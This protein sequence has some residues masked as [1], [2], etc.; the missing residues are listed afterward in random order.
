MEI[1]IRSLSSG[2]IPPYDL[3]LLADPSRKL[4]EE[5]LQRGLCYVAVSG[6]QTLGVLVLIRTR[7]ETMEIVNI[8]VAEA[9]QIKGIG[10]KLIYHAI[11]AAKE[12]GAK[13]FEIGTGKPGVVHM[14]LYQK[15]G[16]RIVGVDQNFFIRHYAE[17]I[18]ENGIQCR[19]MIRMRM[20]I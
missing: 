12:T 13:T 3:L 19:D 7:P 6:A 11:Q 5:Y 15:C 10:R 14:L 17:E 4:V 18:Y 9:W 2:E 16:F 1:Y 20:D 8:A